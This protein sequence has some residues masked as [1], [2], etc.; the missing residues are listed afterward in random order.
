MCLSQTAT[1]ELLELLDFV[2]SGAEASWGLT[3]GELAHAFLSSQ[4]ERIASMQEHRM[5]NGIVEALPADAAARSMQ[6][7]ALFAHLPPIRKGMPTTSKPYSRV[8]HGT[9]GGV[10]GPPP[11][12]G[13]PLISPTQTV[14]P[15]LPISNF[16][17][18]PT[19]KP[20]ALER[21]LRA[22]R[23]LATRPRAGQS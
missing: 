10:F 15:P 3:Q 12:E 9:V 4:P 23:E 7:L 13:K 6:R 17:A 5:L 2:A 11:L 19:P 18:A 8:P 1:P 14:P 20:A 21:K 16:R 22:Q